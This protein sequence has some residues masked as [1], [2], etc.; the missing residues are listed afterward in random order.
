M[1][2]SS[3]EQM[4]FSK[5]KIGH[6]CWIYT[7]KHV[8]PLFNFELTTLW[9][10]NNLLFMSDEENVVYPIPHPSISDLKA[11]SSSQPFWSSNPKQVNATV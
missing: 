7:R 8:T 5:V 11:S 1:N 10:M 3:F 4:Q 9:I 2:F 6:V